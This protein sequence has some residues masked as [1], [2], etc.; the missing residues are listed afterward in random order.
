M[1]ISNA[2]KHTHKLVCPVVPQHQV[3][4]Y[5]V[6]HPVTKSEPTQTELSDI[7]SSPEELDYVNQTQVKQSQCHVPKQINSEKLKSNY[8]LDLERWLSN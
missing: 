1:L 6:E 4:E 8:K 3:E 2:V 5:R 7:T